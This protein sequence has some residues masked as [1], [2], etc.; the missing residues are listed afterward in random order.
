MFELCEQLLPIRGFLS[1][2]ETHKDTTGELIC[3]L[4]N[5]TLE[6]VTMFE[7]RFN[8]TSTL[9]LKIF[10]LRDFARLRP[11]RFISVFDK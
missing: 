5:K 1:C 3:R 6:S 7:L 10:F 4:C 8:R 11:G 2:Q 9:P